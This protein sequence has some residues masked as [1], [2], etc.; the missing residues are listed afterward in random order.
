E[1]FFGGAAGGGKSFGQLLDALIFAL[2]YKKSRQLILR[3]T[4]PELNRSLI[5]TSYEIYPRKLCKYNGG[6]HSFRFSNG[7]IIEFGHVQKEKDV[8]N[9]QSAEYDVIRFDE[10]TH[11][12]EEI[13]VY[14]LSRIRGVNDYPKMVKSTGNPG[15]VGHAWVKK[16]FID[17]SP[18]DT[19]FCLGERKGVYIPSKVTDNPFLLKS[20]PGYIKR[21]GALPDAQRKALLFGDWN[22]FDGQYFSEWQEGL[23]VIKP[24]AIPKPWKR[25]AALDFGRDMLACLWGAVD[26]LGNL[27]IYREVCSGED[28]AKFSDGMCGTLPLTASEAAGLILNAMD[29]NERKEIDF[30]FAPPDLFNKSGQRGES[31][32]EIFAKSGLPLI[33]TKNDRIPGW[34]ALAERL[35]E[36]VLPNGDITAGVRIFSNCRVLIASLPALQYSKLNPND[37]GGEPHHITHAPDALRYLI[38]GRPQAAA[39]NS[40]EREENNEFEEFLKFGK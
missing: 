35:K 6:A 27:V 18:A 21:L 37:I 5:R 3:R 32:A 31:V 19:V 22:I 10:L 17:A 11:F 20:D 14:L 25:Y 24:F 7:S 15:G 29:E 13:Y 2:R 38:A 9:Y 26:S 1:V 33:K 36:R 8:Y 4:F 28:G 23:H 30:C 34:Y 40:Q 39:A 12:T 16:R